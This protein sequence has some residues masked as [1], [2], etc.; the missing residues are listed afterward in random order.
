MATVGK[1]KH[2]ADKNTFCGQIRKR[3]RNAFFAPRNYIP[4]IEAHGSL[5]AMHMEGPTDNKKPDTA[6]PLPTNFYPNTTGFRG[7]KGEEGTKVSN[8]QKA[9]VAE[10]LASPI[11]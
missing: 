8:D 3:R 11:T 1:H 4:F 10:I 5:S 2:F 9:A 7:I 6:S